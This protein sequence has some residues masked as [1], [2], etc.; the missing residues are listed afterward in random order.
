MTERDLV[1]RLRWPEGLPSS[2]DNP[3]SVKLRI[4]AADEIEELRLRL[5]HWREECG[6]LHAKL[7]TPSPGP[8]PR[9][10]T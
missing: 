3:V 6:K 4:E 9:K 1:A 10:L 8:D 7:T 5:R 2:R